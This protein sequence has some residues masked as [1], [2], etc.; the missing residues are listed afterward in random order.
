MRQFSISL[1]DDEVDAVSSLMQ[2]YHMNR[3]QAIKFALR[4]F[5]FPQEQSVPVNGKGIIVDSKPVEKRIVI[6]G[7]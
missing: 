3:H 7:A 1:K 6:R 2:T 4:R 5:L